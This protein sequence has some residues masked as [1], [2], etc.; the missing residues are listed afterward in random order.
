MTNLALAQCPLSGAK[1]E[2]DLVRVRGLD[3]TDAQGY[4]GWWFW[5]KRRKP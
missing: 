5:R 2:C 4:C 1:R 3:D